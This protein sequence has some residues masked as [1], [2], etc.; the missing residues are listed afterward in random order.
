MTD[1]THALCSHPHERPYFLGDDVR[2]K[3]APELYNRH[4]DLAPV[5]QAHRQTATIKDRWVESTYDTGLDLYHPE[6]I[7]LVELHLAGFL[8]LGASQLEPVTLA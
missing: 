4:D 8:V 5:E 3:Y 6:Y 2:I 7:Y 1:N